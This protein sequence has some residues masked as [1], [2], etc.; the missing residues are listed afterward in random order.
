MKNDSARRALA[1]KFL[2]L[3][4]DMEILQERFNAVRAEIIQEG[5]FRAGP[6]VVEV[7]QSARRNI[8]VKTVELKFPAIFKRL[9][10]LGLVVV[11]E[12][13]ALSVERRL[14]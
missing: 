14:K 2:K 5:S 9:L 10:K 7:R 4:D 3:Q 1:R 11:T 12:Y 6:Y 13:P 8:P